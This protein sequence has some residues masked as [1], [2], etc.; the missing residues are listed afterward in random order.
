M[1]DNERKTTAV[2]KGMRMFFPECG[3]HFT[4][5]P[6]RVDSGVGKIYLFHSPPEF[7]EMLGEKKRRGGAFLMA[8]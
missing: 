5:N 3:L 8:P 7:T 4:S 2:S 1:G 6:L